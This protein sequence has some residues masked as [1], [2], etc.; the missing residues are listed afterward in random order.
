MLSDVYGTVSS[1]LLFA[2][3]LSG[4]YTCCM[5]VLHESVSGIKGSRGKTPWKRVLTRVRVILSILLVSLPILL[6]PT[7]AL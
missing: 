7:I 1:G 3:A 5:L 6:M 2:L 4:S